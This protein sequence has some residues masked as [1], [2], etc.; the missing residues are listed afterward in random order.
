ML[1][2]LK[3][4]EEF[5]DC[6]TLSDFGEKAWEIRLNEKDAR[7]AGLYKEAMKVN[8]NW[9]SYAGQ[10]VDY[11]DEN[12][13]DLLDLMLENMPK[14]KRYKEHMR[15][16]YRNARV[17]METNEMLSGN[18]KMVLR[19]VLINAMNRLGVK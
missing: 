12:L 16:D 5:K 6:K 10:Y 15:A 7:W 4:L 13:D 18:E 8:H 1:P 9:L 3:Q 19:N 14:Y 11:I 2:R 17:K